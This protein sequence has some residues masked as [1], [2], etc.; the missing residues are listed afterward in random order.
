LPIIDTVERVQG[1]TVDLVIVSMCV[2][3]VSYANS[4]APFLLSPNRLNVALSRAR[5][6]A[7]LVASTA[8]LNAQALNIPE[9][10]ALHQWRA[11]LRLAPKTI[12][13]LCRAQ[14]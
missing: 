11:A 14:L 12:D 3:D 10:F 1:L 8:L 9:R 6:K 5:T 13:L 2:S 4:I 7:I